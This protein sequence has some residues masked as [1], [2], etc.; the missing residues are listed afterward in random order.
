[1]EDVEKTIQRYE[2]R[3]E[4]LAEQYNEWYLNKC[5]IA[6]YIVEHNDKLVNKDKL[7]ELADILQIY[8]I[9]VF[10]KNGT[11]E[12]TNSSF[13]NF[14]LSQ[15]PEDQSY[16]FNKLLMGVDYLIQEAQP[17]EVSEEFYQYIGV[18]VRDEEGNNNGFV[19]I[20]I[21]P[22][23]LEN[24]LKN[25]QISNV[26]DGVQVGGG[27]FA[28]A[29]DK[30]EGTFTYYPDDTLVGRKATSYGLK[31]S[32]LKDGYC[33]YLTIE[34]EKYYAS[35]VETDDSYVYVAVPDHEI[36]KQRLPL[37]LATGVISF[38]CIILLFILLSFKR[39]GVLLPDRKGTG[40]EE[41]DDRMINVVLPDGRV[42]QTESAASRWMSI[43]L[44]WDEKTPEQQIA[45]VVK[46]LIG[47]LAVAICLGVVF[48]EAI[49]Q[50]DS[51]FNYIVDGGW[52]KGVN[53][54]AITASIMIIAVVM[55]GTEIVK[56]IL[57]LLA[58]VF[59]ARG[60][61][62]CRLIS[63]FIK[64]VAIVAMLYYCFALFGVD[65]AT[66]LASAGILSI[67]ISLGAKDMVGD[68]LA[69]LFIIFEGEFRVGDIVMIGDWRGTVL[70]IGVRTTKIEDGSKNIKIIRNS[71]VTD[72]INMTKRSSYAFCDDYL[73]PEL[74]Q[75]MSCTV[76]SALNIHSGAGADTPVIGTLKHGD[77]IKVS[78]DENDWLRF[79]MEDGTIGYVW[80]EYMAVV[81]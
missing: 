25:M 26:L 57:K 76:K 11:V 73:K 45:T 55:T 78:A 21:R 12:A 22:Q 1:M 8:N 79:T 5:Q 74:P 32:E 40:A 18:A 15:D 60:E 77:K 35:S 36:M 65:T 50:K 44:K 14:T 24:I 64:Y 59:G 47:I 33:D 72:V 17:D 54:F 63:S 39:N 29:V 13:N 3:A 66:L 49:F 75:T 20:A 34:S 46:F 37:T 23:R 80:D 52:E 43:A 42:K 41:E 62:V 38:I 51:I 2:N 7:A 27:G 10:D 81:E 56:R 61:T 16:E 4:E 6:A 30:E 9:F 71:N 19:Q 58:S 70:E 48:R 69:G 28:F 68:I 31:K 53:I 67:A